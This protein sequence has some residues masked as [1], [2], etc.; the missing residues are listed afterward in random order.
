MVLDV[1]LTVLFV[2]GVIGFTVAVC[3]SIL[4]QFDSDAYRPLI[5]QFL[6]RRQ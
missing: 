3:N 2:V 1:L 5:R 4:D 6:R